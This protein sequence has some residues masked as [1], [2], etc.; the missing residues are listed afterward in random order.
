MWKPMYIYDNILPQ[1]DLTIQT[2]SV[3]YE[4]WADDGN[5]LGRSSTSPIMTGCK[6]YHD[7]KKACN[8]CLVKR[9]KEHLK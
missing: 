8:I 1:Q 3:L 5:N 9:G 2:G 4:V 6:H 7:I